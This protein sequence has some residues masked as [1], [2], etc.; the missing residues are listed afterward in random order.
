MDSY[1]KHEHDELCRIG[2]DNI[3]HDPSFHKSREK[4]HDF[5]SEKKKKN[6]S[7]AYVYPEHVLRK[8][9]RDDDLDDYVK[10]KY[11]K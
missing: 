10:E 7:A 1:H 6:K 2:I 9:D 11:G 8:V 4:I 3:M 5:L